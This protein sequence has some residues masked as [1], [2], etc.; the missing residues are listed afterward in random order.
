MGEGDRA[1]AGI[2][3]LER[4]DLLAGDGQR[5]AVDADVVA[6]GGSGESGAGGDGD[7][8]GGGVKGPHAVGRVVGRES[9]ARASGSGGDQ[10]AAEN[11]R[12]RPRPG[13]GGGEKVSVDVADGDRRR[14]G[15]EDARD[16]VA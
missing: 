15:E 3:Q 1:A 6:G 7:L 8:L 9:A 10:G 11:G 16:A 4:V 12:L 2:I 5:G 13:A 14:S